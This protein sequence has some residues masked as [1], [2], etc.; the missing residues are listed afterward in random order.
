MSVPA[1]SSTITGAGPFRHPA[2]FYRGMDEYLA[3]T[4]PFIEAGLAAGEPVAVAVP[5]AQL[6]AIRAGLADAADRVRLIDMTRAGRN[7]GRLEGRPASPRQQPR[8]KDL[9]RLR[10]KRREPLD[11]EELRDPE[12][13]AHF[14]KRMRE[15]LRRS[16]DHAR[17]E[18]Q[19]QDHRGSPRRVA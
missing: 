17:R 18:R 16:E 19:Q 14:H 12:L 1:L 10:R 3:G 6:E 11:Q 8:H 9:R 15:R 2:L 13:F 4:V 7:P 5:G